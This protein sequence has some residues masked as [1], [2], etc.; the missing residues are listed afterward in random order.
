M[1]VALTS[2]IACLQCR[3]GRCRSLASSTLIR[4][5]YQHPCI[6]ACTL[7]CNSCYLLFSCACALHAVNVTHILSN[8]PSRRLANSVTPF[9]LAVLSATIHLYCMRRHSANARRTGC[10]A[11]KWLPSS[12]RLRPTVAK[13]IHQCIIYCLYQSQHRKVKICD[14]EKSDML[15][16]L[17]C[18][19]R[20]CIFSCWVRLQKKKKKNFTSFGQPTKLITCANHGNTVICS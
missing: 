2:C 11:D 7:C 20:L 1:F 8:V 5:L 13:L 16:A 6:A 14:N 4:M 3:T 19:Q 9:K 15:F 17:T 18:A 12:D 10:K